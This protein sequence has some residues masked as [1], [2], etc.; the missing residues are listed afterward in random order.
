MTAAIFRYELRF[1]GVYCCQVK[2]LR[3]QCVANYLPG[4]Y[5]KRWTIAY[6]ALEDRIEC[7]QIVV[8]GFLQRFLFG[9]ISIVVLLGH[10]AIWKVSPRLFATKL[11][12]I[13]LRAT[14]Q[15]SIH[16]VS[17]KWNLAITV[18]ASQRNVPSRRRHS[19]PRLQTWSAVT[20]SICCGICLATLKIR[21]GWLHQEQRETFTRTTSF[22]TCRLDFP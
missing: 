10:S 4:T 21:R 13:Q 8:D 9:S 16:C 19:C 11:A 17:V 14:L 6:F 20:L 22:A 2:S 3:I 5:C 7:G 15:S 18:K 1:D 12:T